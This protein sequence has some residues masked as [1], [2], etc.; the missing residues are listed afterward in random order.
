M[1]DEPLYGLD[2]G[3]ISAQGGP[4]DHRKSTAEARGQK[5]V[6]TPTIGSNEAGR[7]GGSGRVHSEEAEKDRSVYCDGAD[8]GNL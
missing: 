6:V 8:Y 2:S 7:A 1:G 5:L 3:N 4:P